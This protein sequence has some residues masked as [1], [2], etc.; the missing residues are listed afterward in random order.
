MY[1]PAYTPSL[2]LKKYTEI[3]DLLGL[4]LGAESTSF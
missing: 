2:R 3:I 4:C 1:I